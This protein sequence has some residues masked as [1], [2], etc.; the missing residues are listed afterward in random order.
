M[1]GAD[2][3]FTFP[4]IPLG[5]DYSL[6]AKKDNDLLNGVT[7]FDM[8]LI[9]RH[10]LNIDTL[11]SPYKIIAADVNR[12]NSVTTQDLVFLRK[13][14]LLINS[15]FPNNESWRFVDANYVFPNPYDPFQETFPEYFNINNFNGGMQDFDFIAIKIGDVNGTAIPNQ[16]VQ[17]PENRSGESLVFQLT[18]QEL[19]PGEMYLLDFTAQNFKEIASYQFTLKFDPEVLEFFE[20]EPVK[21]S[22]LERPVRA[23]NFGFHLTDQGL[24]TTSWNDFR[25]GNLSPD[26]ALFRLQFQAHK[27]GRLS[28][29]LRI[30]SGFTKA[31]AYKSAA[32]NSMEL[33]DV[34]LV[35][36]SG[37]GHKTNYEQ[38]TATVSPNPFGET[39]V[40]GFQLTEA[41]EVTLNVFDP[42]GRLV[43]TLQG[44]FG[45]GRGEFKLEAGDLSAPGMYFYRLQTKNAATGG[46]LVKF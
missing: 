41:Q 18:D 37:T 7:S 44:S 1:T 30:A 43:K 14:I 27:K 32:D 4:A 12:S 25:P 34:Q 22:A 42:A 8:V 10:V 35:F 31:E 19:E 24:I 45:K 46:Q 6:S 38:M 39:T 17:P 40:I 20:F 33:L 3:N 26:A 13:A 28:E 11:G 21:S 9:Q 2:G 36:K 15:E 29:I 5:G 23:D 16:L